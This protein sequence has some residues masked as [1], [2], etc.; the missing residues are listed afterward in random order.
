MPV[1]PF[2]FGSRYHLTVIDGFLISLNPHKNDE[3]NCINAKDCESFEKI[4]TLQSTFQCESLSK[5]QHV[6][7][8]FLMTNNSLLFDV[9]TEKEYVT[10]VNKKGRYY[11]RRIHLSKAT[12][13]AIAVR[14]T[15]K[16]GPQSSKY[17]VYGTPL[18]S[19]HNETARLYRQQEEDLGG[20]CIEKAS[21]SPS[22]EVSRAK[23]DLKIKEV[24]EAE[25][26]KLTRRVSVSTDYADHLQS[27]LTHFKGALLNYCQQ[28]SL[29]K[30][31][32]MLKVLLQVPNLMKHTKQLDKLHEECKA[33]I[34]QNVLLAHEKLFSS[35][36]ASVM[37]CGG[38]GQAFK[39]D[40]PTLSHELRPETKMAFEQQPSIKL[41]KLGKKSTSE[42]VPDKKQATMSE[43]PMKSHSENELENFKS[44]ENAVCTNQF[45]DILESGSQN[46]KRNI[47]R[48]KRQHKIT[49]PSRDEN[50]TYLSGESLLNFKPRA[51]EQVKFS[52]EGQDPPLGE[53]IRHLQVFCGYSEQKLLYMQ[54]FEDFRELL[55]F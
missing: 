44:R 37:N 8:N 51:L 50:V 11:C 30:L 10:F 43:N 2:I 38:R 55:N 33:L 12:H 16:K 24:T 19:K 41:E 53:F 36:F 21:G 7:S 48:A 22:P 3:A 40:I 35:C 18:D 26:L 49:K 34:K 13:V 9:V 42:E 14:L 54:T 1:Y 5:L 52:I 20:Y 15:W 28:R 32:E 23:L 46:L 25:L 4:R 27:P 47:T 6:S 17:V 29:N 39:Q 31:N 45:E